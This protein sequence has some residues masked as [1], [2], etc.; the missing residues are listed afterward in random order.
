MIQTLLSKH[1]FFLVLWEKGLKNVLTIE[2]TLYVTK[3]YA[4]KQHNLCKYPNLLK[5]FPKNPK[6]QQIFLLMVR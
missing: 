5:T 3:G 6:K 1:K 4:T 2:R